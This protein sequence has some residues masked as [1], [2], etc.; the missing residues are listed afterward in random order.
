MEPSSANKGF[1][2]V[3]PVLRNQFHEDVT[4]QRVMK[5]MF[6]LQFRFEL[7]IWDIEPLLL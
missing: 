4:L 2:Q 1:I 7:W 6:S 3:Q 5:R